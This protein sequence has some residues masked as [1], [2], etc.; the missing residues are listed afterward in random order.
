MAQ[1][2]VN[3]NL[4]LVVGE[5]SAGKSASLRNLRNPEGVIFLNCEAGKK[6]PFRS[7]F[8][9]FTITDPYQIREAFQALEDGKIKGHTVVIDTLTYLLDMYESLYIIG[10]ANGQAAWNNFQQYFKTL[11]Q[12]YVA[13]AK[14]NVVFLAH[15]KATYNE[16]RMEM[17][18][19]VPV[20][21]ALKNNGIE[22]YFS[23]VISAKKMTL[24]NL[25][26]Y[27][28]HNDMLV[29]SAQEEALGYKHVFQTMITKETVG[30]RIR[31]PMGMWTDPQTYIDNDLQK[32]LDHMHT[33]YS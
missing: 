14:V 22:S 16:A 3:D 8:Q 25:E 21:G 19:S 33:Y 31:G 23:T 28:E 29:V 5:S 4:I 15:T 10:A 24:R 12:D 11:M 13:R 30:E 17:E 32:V 6:L 20:K 7:K 9:E 26:S 2:A 18:V 1:Q 27:R